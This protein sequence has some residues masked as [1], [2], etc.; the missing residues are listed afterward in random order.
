[1]QTRDG[2]VA[3]QLNLKKKIEF[4]L[5]L[6]HIQRDRII[7]TDETWLRLLPVAERGWGEP[8]S[9]PEFTAGAGQGVTL[10][11]SVTLAPARRAFC[12][13]LL[14]GKTEQVHPSVALPE[15]VEMWHSPNHWACEESL[16]KVVDQLDRAMQEDGAAEPRG[17]LW[18]IDAA[19]C[20]TA[21]SFLSWLKEQRPWVH[22]CFVPAGYT[23]VCQPCDVAFM[24]SFKSSLRSA[25]ADDTA[26]QIV[27]AAAPGDAG[28]AVP[29]L[30][31]RPV[32]LRKKL[33]HWVGKALNSF[34]ENVA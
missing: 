17:W 21:A 8:G 20:H 28:L 7:N 19:P 33:V 24:R 22:A 23:A 10:T 4:L 16:Q 6:H 27:R 13:I 5:R 14:E 29:K 1:V 30:D 9:K 31:V 25:A 2:Q 15:N 11:L 34:P 32:S 18:V 12:Q 26:E 3:A